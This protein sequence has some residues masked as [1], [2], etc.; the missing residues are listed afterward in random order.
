MSIIN[1]PRPTLSLTVWK[2][3]GDTYVLS[4]EAREVI[5]SA[6]RSFP[7][8]DLLDI[9]KEIHIVGSITTNTYED[10]CDVDVHIIPDEDK[11]KKYLNSANLSFEDFNER[12][13]KFYKKEI[14][15]IGT[16]PVE[17][18]IQANP[19]QDL[20]SD[21]V[22]SFTKDV[23]KKGPLLRGET[24]NPRKVFA[25]IY[26]L[27]KKKIKNVDVLLGQVKR[28]AIDYSAI[29]KVID[30][31]SPEARKVLE[32]ELEEIVDNLFKNIDELLKVKKEWVELRRKSSAPSSPEEA[33][34]SVK[35]VRKWT[36]ANALFKL[37]DL[38][39]YLYIISELE[40]A[41]SDDVLTP[42]EIEDIRKK[43][44][45]RKDE[46]VRML[47][48]ISLLESILD[49]HYLLEDRETRR[50][51]LKK[52]RDLGYLKVTDADIETALD[53][54][55][56]YA[57]WIL[58]QVTKGTIKL[59]QDKDLIAKLIK[60]FDFVKKSSRFT[61]SKDI[62][63]YKTL[64]DLKAQV[65]K[66]KTFEISKG[67][68]KRRATKEG[69]RIVA[70]DPPYTVIEITTPE[71]SAK[72][73]RDTKWCVKDPDYF[74]KYIKYG[75]IYLVL[76]NGKKFLCYSDYDGFSDVEN[77]PVREV[78]KKLFDIFVRLKTKVARFASPVS[79]L[80][81]GQYVS[82]LRDSGL[83]VTL[84]NG[85]IDVEGDV[86]KK[87]VYCRNGKIVYSFGKV[88]GNFLVEGLPLRTLEGAP[89]YVGGDFDC[90]GCYELTYL[91]GAPRRVEGVFRCIDCKDL[92]SLEGA[93]EYV[94]KDFDCR[95]CYSLTSLKGAP[96]RVGRDFDCSY[97][98]GLTSL[99]GAPRRVE[100]NFNCSECENLKSLEGAPEYVGGNFYCWAC[101]NLTSFEGA[102][103]YVGGNLYCL[104]CENLKSLQGA[105]EYVG[106][107]FDCS[108]CPSLTSLKGAPERVEGHF[109]C[110]GCINL[111]SLEGA[112]EYVGGDFYCAYCPNLTS[113]KGL[114][115]VKGKI[116]AKG[117]PIKDLAGFPEDKV[118][119]K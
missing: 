117:T 32:N 93:P 92:L 42:Y 110:S 82:F 25:H 3:E 54:S 102:P 99:K 50:Q 61:G 12:V 19:A 49:G 40:K 119:L 118:V 13:K 7:Y 33:L 112:S 81:L 28:D 71:A 116:Y 53:I 63:A 87:F 90:S 76:K 98:H 35:L 113:L 66:S 91:K 11:L 37:L 34:N 6:L 111:T 5:L 22:Y 45:Y 72:L 94:G 96:E 39:E 31:L 78:D 52:K 80:S 24:Y 51:D 89:E 43:L 95:H 68:Q 23:W 58:I 44:S 8:V 20:L 26:E 18:Y 65:E 85:K 70:E 104:G 114:K 79:E 108:Y 69:Q 77:H 14:F 59:P 17:I 46:S 56:P 57:Y 101:K 62:Y 4:D 103:E 100:G 105:P 84:R 67:E 64:Q 74:A 73:L 107:D 109:V 2:L 1:Y 29:K 55:E 88:S 10:T 48:D 27:L 86:S 38:Y 83:K 47:Y 16:H 75:P 15:K 106:G 97:C 30:K 36:D 60:D 41:V 115:V 21:G 9:A